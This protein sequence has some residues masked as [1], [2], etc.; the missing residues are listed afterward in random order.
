MCSPGFLSTSLQTTF[1][2]VLVKYALAAEKPVHSTRISDLKQ[3]ALK[4]APSS[5]TLSLDSEISPQ[6][7]LFVFLPQFLGD[8]RMSATRG[9][10]PGHVGGYHNRQ[11]FPPNSPPP[12]LPRLLLLVELGFPSAKAMLRLLI[13]AVH[14]NAAVLDKKK[15][16]INQDCV[17]RN[18]TI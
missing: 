7:H 2:P 15:K 6:S 5:G 8:P 13:F 11:Y 17:R 18:V 9:R 10:A 14:T 16:S 1:T 4:G 12:F 3:E